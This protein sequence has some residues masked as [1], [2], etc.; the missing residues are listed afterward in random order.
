MP[1]TVHI[2]RELE[3]RLVRYHGRILADELEHFA[4]S[5]SDHSIFDPTHKSLAIFAS[6]VDFADL[7]TD[8]MRAFESRVLSA[9]GEMN[10]ARKR[11]AAIVA[12]SKV[13]LDQIREW[14]SRLDAH[15]GDVPDLMIFASTEGAANWLGLST[16]TANRIVGRDG[17]TQVYPHG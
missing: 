6:D 11:R 17:F 16:T 5:F 10:K 13:A 9:Y 2:D 15:P 4:A 7:P 1:I 3:L 12:T 8:A 14:R